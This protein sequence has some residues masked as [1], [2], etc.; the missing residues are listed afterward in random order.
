M[1]VVPTLFTKK[2]RILMI[3]TSVLLDDIDFAKAM[4]EKEELS[5]GEKWGHP[6]KGTLSRENNSLHK[7]RL[8]FFS[9]PLLSQRI[10][11]S[12]LP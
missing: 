7:R 4:L 3:D 12:L 10:P 8:I 6:L 2:G 1:G 5:N 9:Y 11:S